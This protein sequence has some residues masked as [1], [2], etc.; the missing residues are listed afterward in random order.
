MELNRLSG[1]SAQMSLTINA[2]RCTLLCHFIPTKCLYQWQ[3]SAHLTR[4]VHILLEERRCICVLLKGA[5]QAAVHINCD[6]YLFIL[7]RKDG[8]FH[9]SH[10]GTSFISSYPSGDN[11]CACFGTDKRIGNSGSI[12]TLSQSCWYFLQACCNCIISS[13]YQNAF[14]SLASV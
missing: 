7:Y 5:D 12:V 2:L 6:I 11:S 3:I 10:I 4:G 9:A 8:S 13:R 1:L 14:A